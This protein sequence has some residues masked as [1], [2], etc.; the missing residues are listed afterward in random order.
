VDGTLKHS[1]TPPSRATEAL[2]VRIPAEHA[3]RLDRAAFELR[4]PK[5]ALVSDLLA[6][7]IDPDSPASLAALAGAPGDGAVASSTPRAR[8]PRAEGGR[9]R[10]TVETLEPDTLVVG[11][12]SFR[13][14]EPERAI[15]AAPEVLRSEQAAELLQL[16][17]AAVERLAEQGELPA[18]KLA[19]EWRLSRAALLA[20]LAQ[21]APAPAGGAD[22]RGR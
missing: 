2:F 12:H 8:G 15:A 18:R 20:W 9:R 19:G 14:Q 16:T 5:Q 7:Y 1:R 21:P 13:P 6:R 22:E 11:H 3:R 10:V 4:R 17:A